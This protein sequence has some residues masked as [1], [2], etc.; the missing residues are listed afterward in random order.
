MQ[1]GTKYMRLR[2]PVTI[3]SRFGDWEVCWLGGWSRYRLHYLVMAVRL[4]SDDA[5]A[6]QGGDIPPPRGKSN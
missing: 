3:G 5:P 2:T 6:N 1:I 4:I